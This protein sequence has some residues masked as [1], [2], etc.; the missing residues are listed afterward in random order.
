MLKIH[1][2]GQSAAEARIE[3]GSTTILE[4]GVHSSE[5]KYPAPEKGEDIVSSCMKV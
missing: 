4:I 3:Q 5:W 2:I 1:Q